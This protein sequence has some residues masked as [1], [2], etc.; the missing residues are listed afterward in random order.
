MRE[1]IRKAGYDYDIDIVELKI[2]EY[3]IHKVVRGISMMCLSDVM[4]VIMSISSRKF[5]RLY[6]EIKKRFLWEENQVLRVTL[7]K[8]IENA[9][10]DFI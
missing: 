7:L 1:I 3:H 8:S 10:E 6:L 9:N 5:F 2:T 4:Q